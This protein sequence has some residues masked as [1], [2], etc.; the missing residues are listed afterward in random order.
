MYKALI[1]PHIA[2]LLV[3]FFVMGHARV[4]AQAQ[5]ENPS[6]GTFQFELLTCSPGP[7][8]Y[9]LYGH[10]GLRVTD[11]R[12]MDVVFN[13]GVFDFRKPHFIWNFLLGKTDYMVAAIPY[14]YFL[15]EYRERGSSVTSQHLNL[16][17]EESTRLW[18]ALVENAKPQNCEYRYN[19]LLNNCTSKVR[20]MIENAIDGEVKYKEAE[21][22]TYRDCLHVYTE[23]HP[24]AEVGDDMLL[25]ASVDTVLS[26]RMSAFLPERLM[27]FYDQAV[28]YDKE[29]NSRPLLQGETTVLLPKRV[30]PREPE[31]PLTPWQAILCFAGI[32][33]LVFACEIAFKRMIWGFDILVMMSQGLC[34][35]LACF[36]FLFSEH[37]SVDSNWQVLLFN[38][39]PLLCMPWVVWRAIKRKYCV[40]HFANL[41]FLLL[42]LAFSPWIPQRF[43]LL[44]IPLACTLLLRPLSYLIFYKRM[45]GRQG[46]ARNERH[47]PERAHQK[48]KK[49]K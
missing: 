18:N 24:W 32:S 14:E 34:G 9:S 28:V 46:A 19:F 3:L 17:A 4:C 38:P 29:G 42:F 47:T 23:G 48:K 21:K 13:Y 12:G 8:V 6:E 33:L 20:D 10:T 26:D 11:G 36:M 30:V 15:V 7:E 49:K 43:A 35:A 41:S 2:F 45:P 31:F 16:T 39:I 44:T 25:G 5:A 1:R 22:M 37:P 40:Y 27:A